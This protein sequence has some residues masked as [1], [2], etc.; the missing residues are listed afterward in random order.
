MLVT[1]HPPI[2]GWEF[3]ASSSRALRS[4]LR[5]FENLVKPPIRFHESLIDASDGWTVSGVLRVWTVSA[6]PLGRR[7]DSDVVRGRLNLL[8][9]L[10]S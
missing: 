8:I 4:R 9:V 1:P 7:S 5:C 10:G 2:S 3:P 6:M